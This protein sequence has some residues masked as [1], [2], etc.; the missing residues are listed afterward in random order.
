MTA[1]QPGSRG[2][3]SGQSRRLQEA[4]SFERQPTPVE[5]RIVPRSMVSDV[6]HG[7][8]VVPL[9]NEVLSSS[10]CSFTHAF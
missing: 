6:K 10:I 3:R 1:P 8:T 2:G 5:R 4:L 9:T 7:R